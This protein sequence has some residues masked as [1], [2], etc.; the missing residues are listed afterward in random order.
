M[1]EE[2]Q[3]LT[4]REIERARNWGGKEREGAVDNKLFT[5]LILSFW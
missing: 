1:E 2:K 3:R 4:L 5:L